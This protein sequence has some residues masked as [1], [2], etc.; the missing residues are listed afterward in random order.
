MLFKTVHLILLANRRGKKEKEIQGNVVMVGDLM[1]IYGFKK[2]CNFRWQILSWLFRLFRWPYGRVTLWQSNWFDYWII[3][4]SCTMTGSS[5]PV[6]LWLLAP[7]KLFLL[8]SVF[9]LCWEPYLVQRRVGSSLVALAWYKS[10]IISQQT[11][12]YDVCSNY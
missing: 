6:S 9:T 11:T 2:S 10:L 1:V 4:P 3:H 8:V 12:K 7:K 5:L